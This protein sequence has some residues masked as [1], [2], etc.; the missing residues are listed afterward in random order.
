M[1]L[2]KYA[3]VPAEI[4]EALIKQHGKPDQGRK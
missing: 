4:Q 1:E 2:S 3:P